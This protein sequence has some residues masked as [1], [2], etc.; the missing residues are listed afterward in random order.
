MGLHTYAIYISMRDYDLAVCLAMYE[1]MHQTVL[2]R[3][4]FASVEPDRPCVVMIEVVV[5]RSDEDDSYA[6]P[7]RI[8]NEDV[9]RMQCHTAADIVSTYSL[10]AIHYSAMRQYT[11]AQKDKWP[12]NRRDGS[13]I[14]NSDSHVT[15]H[16]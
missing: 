1:A 8:T 4:C 7:K 14:G 16:Y 12:L 11:S 6:L 2:Q 15:H 10:H 5:V 9:T 3:E 13:I